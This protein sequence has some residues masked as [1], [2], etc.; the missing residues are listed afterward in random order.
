M[1]RAN[2][3]WMKAISNLKQ[4]NSLPALELLQDSSIQLVWRFKQQ[5]VTF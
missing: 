1:N 3:F 4:I 2:V 5:T